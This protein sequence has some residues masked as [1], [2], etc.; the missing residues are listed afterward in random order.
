MF[1]KPTF[2]V[3]V[4][5]CALNSFVFRNLI[6]KSNKTIGVLNKAFDISEVSKPWFVSTLVRS[7]RNSD[8]CGNHLNMENI[9]FGNHEKFPYPSGFLS[10]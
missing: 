2:D 10:S 5:I 8:V 3:I 7:S 4:S 1:R 6:P 9:R